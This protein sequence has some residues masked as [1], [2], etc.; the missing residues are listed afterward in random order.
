MLYRIDTFTLP[1]S[2][3]AEFTARSAM[4]VDLLR[5]QPGFVRD[6]WFQKVAGDGSV[7]V[8]T[9]VEWRDEASIAA[10]GQAV[11]ALHAGADFD[12]AAFLQQYGVS[13]AVYAEAPHPM[14]ADA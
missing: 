2:A 8:I 9:M 13:R 10:A 5:R 6:H 4:T 12:A 11:R 1:E 7:N 3:M 14:C